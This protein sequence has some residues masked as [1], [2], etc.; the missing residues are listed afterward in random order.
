MSTRRR[1]DA[2]R[3][4]KKG[5]DS[6]DGDGQKL[7]SAT[8]SQRSTCTSRLL[9]P[10]QETR[11]G[12]ITR[13]ETRDSR[14]HREKTRRTLIKAGTRRDQRTRLHPESTS[15]EPQH[16]VEAKTTSAKPTTP[17]NKTRAI[18]RGSTDARAGWSRH[19]QVKTESWCRA[20]RPATTKIIPSTG[21]A[22][23]SPIV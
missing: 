4:P 13:R 1:K 10:H 5:S 22:I 11:R 16:T 9:P 2:M 18:L 20:G 8:P 12:K 17:Q 23:T 3:H 7:I 15:N 14:L 6:C 19:F 21:L